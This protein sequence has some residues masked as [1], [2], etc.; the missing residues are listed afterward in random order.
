MLP[1]GRVMFLTLKSGKSLRWG[2]MQAVR[3]AR[4]R[5]QTDG[6]SSSCH[7]ETS[8]APRPARRAVSSLVLMSSD[9]TSW[10]STLMFGYA[11]LKSA[12]TAFGASLVQPQKVTVPESFVLGAA[13]VASGAFGSGQ[14]ALLP[15]E[16]PDLSP[17]QAGNASSRTQAADAEARRRPR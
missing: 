16:P 2:F 9:P 15:A 11:L 8:G 17:P 4:G 3:L 6:A 5:F 13:A 1:S 12:R 7:S 14:I 10:T